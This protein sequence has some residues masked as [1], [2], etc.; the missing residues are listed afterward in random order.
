MIK[1]TFITV[2]LSIFM[3]SCEDK[4]KSISHDDSLKI[5]IKKDSSKIE[6]ADLPIA[7]D[8]TDY[9]I[10]PVGYISE[11]NSR[12]SSYSSKSGSTS[13][14]V[15][16][17]NNFSISGKLS[18][19]KFQHLNSEK[20]ST[21]TDEIIEI[22]AVHFLED[23][24]Q[25]TGL[26]FLVYTIRDADT[27]KDG[28][29]N[30]NDVETLY[31]SAIN[32]KNLQKLTPN[33]AQIVDWKIVTPLNRLY[34]KSISDTNKNGEFDKKDNVNYQYIN[35]EDDGLKVITYNPLD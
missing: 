33:L 12:F 18:N 10:H 29:L 3:M 31:I 16:R 8:S 9:L 23:I 22:T 5:Q 26:Q 13:Y 7:I 32:G 25:Q 30:S 15:S 34:F 1:L 35:L 28:K 4:S 11:Y 20:T 19:I 21:L 6:I 24:R 27:N 2:C 17:Y 14:A